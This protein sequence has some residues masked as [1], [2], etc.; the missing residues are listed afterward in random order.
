MLDLFASF[1]VA[2]HLVL[3]L[4]DSVSGLTILLKFLP[5]KVGPVEELAL[6]YSHRLVVSFYAVNHLI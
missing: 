5:P 2:L 4:L 3:E 1:M 6:E